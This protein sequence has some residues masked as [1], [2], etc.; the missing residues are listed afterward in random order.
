MVVFKEVH[1][2][3]KEKAGTDPRNTLEKDRDRKSETLPPCDKPH[4]AEAAR[5]RDS[6]E[7]CDDGIR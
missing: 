1:M 3:T 7:A 2:A 6:D 4:V 5:N